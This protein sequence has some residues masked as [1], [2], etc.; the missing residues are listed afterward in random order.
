MAAREYMIEFRQ[1]MGVDMRSM[2]RACKVSQTLL[3]MRESNDKEVTHPVIAERVGKKY[4]LTKEQIEGMKPENYR[5]SSPN[6]DPN[7]YRM[8]TS[9]DGFP[10]CGT[11]IRR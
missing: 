5:K 4:K 6:Y 10:M 9:N 11:E 8:D 2:A 3:A 7:R 1:R